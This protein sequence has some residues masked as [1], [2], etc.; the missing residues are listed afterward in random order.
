MSQKILDKTGIALSFFCL[1]HCLVL[2]ILIG[3]FP[4]ISSLNFITDE[5]FHLLLLVLIL[6]I[7]M[8]SLLLGCFKHRNFKVLIPAGLGVLLLILGINFHEYEKLLTIFGG[9]FLAS[10]HIINYKLCKIDCHEA[11]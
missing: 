10:S 9:L 3:I 7:A 5:T 6:P 1:I 8:I 4:I 11:K 2:P